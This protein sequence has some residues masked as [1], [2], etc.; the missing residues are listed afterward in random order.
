MQPLHSLISS[1]KPKT[2]TFAW[3]DSALAS[4]N[5]TKDALANASLLSYP[6]SD[7]PTCLM[8]DASD[9]A[10]GAVLQQNINGKWNPISFF[11][12]KI[13]PAETRYSTFDRELLGVY[14]SIKKF[15]HFLEGRLFHVL[16]DHKPLTYALNVRSN[17]HSPRQARHL[18][19]IV[20]F[21]STI[22]HVSGTDNVV[23]DALSRI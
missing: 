4:F 19:F 23:A 13:T 7:A 1:A 3:N 14:F 10:V 8:T 5:A 18:D 22:R 12:R 15:R 2:Q 11:S 21:T 6:Q 20:Q 9:T 17:R 16:T